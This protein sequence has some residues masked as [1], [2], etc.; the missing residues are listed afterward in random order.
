LH[1]KNA[2]VVSPSLSL[3]KRTGQFNRR[4]IT[5]PHREDGNDGLPAP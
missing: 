4:P 1:G 5:A 2:L 3:K